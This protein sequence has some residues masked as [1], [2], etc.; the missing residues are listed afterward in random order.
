MLNTLIQ[1]SQGKMECVHCRW[2]GRWNEDELGNWWR[3]WIRKTIYHWRPLAHVLVR[4][5]TAFAAKWGPSLTTFPHKSPWGPWKNWPGGSQASGPRAPR[6]WG[7]AGT[8]TC[9]SH[10]ALS[11][12][13]VGHLSCSLFNPFPWLHGGLWNITEW[14]ITE[15]VRDTFNAPHAQAVSLPIQCIHL[16]CVHWWGLT[17][18]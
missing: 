12:R 10:L 13:T 3:Q 16:D 15:S 17:R 6:V 2:Q 9:F 1:Q 18:A 4:R 5:F 8:M 11:S 7:A 14:I